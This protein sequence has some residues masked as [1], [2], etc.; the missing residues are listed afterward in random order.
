MTLP[1]HLDDAAARLKEAT[2]RIDQAR[3]QPATVE[4]LR[5]WLDALTDFSFALSELHQLNNES[6]HEKL[7]E[8]VGHRG[9]QGPWTGPATR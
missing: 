6:I 7:H 5:A 2:W 9:F 3:E 4:S 1:Q 8:L